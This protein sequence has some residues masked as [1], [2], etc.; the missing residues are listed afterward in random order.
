MLRISKSSFRFLSQCLLSAV[1][2]SG[3]CH[4]KADA[5]HPLEPVDTSSPRATL[6][7]FLTEI[8]NLFQVFRDEYWDSPSYEGYL[9]IAN[10]AGRVLR[11]MDLSEVAPS[12]IRGTVYGI[13]QNPKDQLTPFGPNSVY[14]LLNSLNSESWC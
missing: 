13:G 4:V 8:D 1:L 7:G 9:D 2:L 14:C 3:Y 6:T 11:T 10:R 12:G 5:S